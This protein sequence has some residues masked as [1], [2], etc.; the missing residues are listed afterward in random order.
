MRLTFGKFLLIASNICSNLAV[1]R[2]IASPSARKIFL[3]EELFSEEKPKPLEA[4][5]WGGVIDNLGAGFL[6][7][8]LPQVEL[9][10]N[11]C[12]IGLAKGAELNTTVMPF[13]LRG[14]SL[15]GISSNNCTMQVRKN[16]WTRL[17]GDL[18]PECLLDQISEEVKLDGVLK[19][20]KEILNHKS[21]GRVLV[22]IKSS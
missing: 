6:E 10:G 13:I 15:L 21:R 7:S 22:D 3:Y 18:K 11:V 1:D 17:G 8:V 19:A 12:S 4:I 16:L 9:W 20:S 2:T 5:K 14:V